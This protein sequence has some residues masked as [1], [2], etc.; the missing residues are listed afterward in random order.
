[1]LIKFATTEV[2]TEMRRELVLN[3][4]D[5]IR[6]LWMSLWDSHNRNSSSMATIHSHFIKERLDLDLREPAHANLYKQI[7]AHRLLLEL[8]TIVAGSID[9]R[10]NR[11]IQVEPPKTKRPEAATISQTVRRHGRGGGF[12][13]ATRNTFKKTVDASRKTFMAN[14]NGKLTGSTPSD[15]SSEHTEISKEAQSTLEFKLNNWRNKNLTGVPFA[16]SN[17]AELRSK[18]IQQ[19]TSSSIPTVGLHSR[20]VPDNAVIN[21]PRQSSLDGLLS[22]RR[23]T[24]RR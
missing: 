23:H 22:P 12:G 15:H 10:F 9:E 3:T 24:G 1:M 2:V 6:D 16:G 8:E 5:Q 18:R 7:D 11:Q 17:F 14:M 20:W 13:L 21:E 4:Y 19:T